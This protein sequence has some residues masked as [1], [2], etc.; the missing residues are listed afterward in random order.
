MSLV[1]L[2]V[3]WKLRERRGHDPNSAL[4]TAEKKIKIEALNVKLSLKYVIVF[5]S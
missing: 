4:R 2:S 5:N 3:I 1:R